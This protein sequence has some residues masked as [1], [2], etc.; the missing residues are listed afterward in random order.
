MRSAAHPP[1]TLARRQ[2]RAILAGLAGVALLAWLDLARMTWDMHRAM[3]A[4]IACE[5]H[6]WT[7]ADAALTFLM[8][9]VMMVGMMLPSAAPMSLLFASVARKAAAQGSAVA[10]AF[11]FSSGYLAAWTLFSVGA[12]A[13]Q[14]WLER[15]AL[16]SPMLASASPLFGGG[17]LVLAGLYQWSPWKDACLDHCRAPAHFFAQHWR[18]GAWGAFRMGLAHGLYCLGCCA[19]LMGLLFVGGVMN[20]LWVAGITLFVL[21]EKIAPHGERIARLAGAGML[22]AGATQ[23]WGALAHA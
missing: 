6:P 8:W 19:L 21:V 11:V 16:L 18:P 3:Q 4:G 20:L 10:P 1:G 5:L 15:A 13:L 23:I 17:V 12:T 9:A 7:A 2:R 22:L 14:W